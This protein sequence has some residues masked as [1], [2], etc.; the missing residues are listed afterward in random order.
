MKVAKAKSNPLRIAHL[1]P[2]YFSPDSVVGGGERYVYY[3]AQALRTA[4]GFEQC[5]FTIGPDD[6]LFA[7]DGIPVRIFRNESQ[8]HGAMNG[9]S[10]ALWREL[11]GF[12]L[13]HVHQSLTLFGAYTLAIVKS[14][15]IPAIGTDLGGGENTLMLNRRGMELLDGVISIS[16]YA[17]RLISSYFS[18]RHEIVIGPVDTDRFAPDSRVT[19]SPRAVLCVSR[20]MPHKGIDRVIAALPSELSLT[21]IGRVYH[22][23]YYDLLRTM[24]MGKDVRFVHDADDND[25][26][27]H[28]RS[29]AL[30]VQASTARDIYGTTVGKP[31][32][33]GLTTLE[34]M[35]CGLP[36]VVSDTGSLPE[37]VPDRRFGRV[38]SGHAE[39]TS[40]FEDI[41]DGKWPTPGAAVLARS[42]V[43]Q[44]HGMD[45]IGKRLSLFYRTVLNELKR[46][47]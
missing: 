37:L 43:V 35:S 10:S 41:V 14:L 30:F 11:S 19:K 18:G 25:L 23:A 34:A 33:M 44:Q 47:N 32:L 39:L 9:F 8:T 38:F 15:G 46:S 24:S 13:V 17:H 31:E 28:Y 22:D 1:T 12:D 3:L 29:S 7:Q 21:V 40:I 36:A 4:G 45:A 16:Q 27:C 42:H 26:L 5:V 6:G 2:A 20:I